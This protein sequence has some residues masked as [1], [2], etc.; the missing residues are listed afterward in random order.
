MIAWYRGDTNEGGHLFQSDRGHHSNMMAASEPALVMSWRTVRVKCSRRDWVKSAG[1][2]H[3]RAGWRRCPAREANEARTKLRMA[4]RDF[5]QD[6]DVL[7]FPVAGTPA[8]PHDHEPDFD[9]R[10]LGSAPN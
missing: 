9:K 7:I 5:F 4:S 6:H 2:C 10:V 8:F 1:R 3:Q